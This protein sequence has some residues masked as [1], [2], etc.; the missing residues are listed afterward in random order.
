MQER[1]TAENISFIHFMECLAGSGVCINSIQD[2]ISADLAD[3]ERHSYFGYEQ[4][5]NL[6]NKG[7]KRFYNSVSSGK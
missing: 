5:L 7:R 6:D 4:L 3:T 2:L 1:N